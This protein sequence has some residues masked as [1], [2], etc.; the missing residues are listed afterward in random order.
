MVTDKQKKIL[1]LLEIFDKICRNKGIWYSLTS[2]SILGAV[3]HHGFIPWD[4]DCDV[5]VKIDELNRLRKV[6]NTELPDNIKLYIWDKESKYSQLFDRLTFKDI[7]HYDLHID[8]FPLIGVPENK[9]RRKVFVE[10]CRF[11]VGFLHCKYKNIEYVRIKNRPLTILCKILSKPIPD[12][13]IRRYINWLE[14]KYDL[15]NSTYAYTVCSGYGQNEC[16]PRELFLDTIDFKFEELVVKIPKRY[17][18]YLKS[19][20]GDYMVPKKRNYKKHH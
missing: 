4:E 7:S 16:L 6:L 9:T 5:F 2:G 14:S 3:R 19:I 1:E 12:S 10:L 17:D 8:I 18:I 15:R 20:Y 11:S 13:F